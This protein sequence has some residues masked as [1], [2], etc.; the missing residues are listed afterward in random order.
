MGLT[1]HSLVIN[2]GVLWK[3]TIPNHNYTDSFTWISG[4]L[5]YKPPCFEDVFHM[6]KIINLDPWFG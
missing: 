5:P 2:Y 3:L 6:R 4:K 1:F